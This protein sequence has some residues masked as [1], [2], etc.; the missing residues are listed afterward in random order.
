MKFL[1]G[2]SIFT[3]T[4]E[5]EEL[6]VLAYPT[7]DAASRQKLSTDYWIKGLHDDMEIA[8]KSKYEDVH[9]E[10]LS[11][12]AK[13]A[14]RLTLAGVKIHRS[15]AQINTVTAGENQACDVESIVC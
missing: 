10:T 13:E 7:F 1:P 3:F 5:I 11:A 15:S 12:L 14:D 4:F 2:K 8:L 9:A 6:V